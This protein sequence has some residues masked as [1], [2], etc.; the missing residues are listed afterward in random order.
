MKREKTTT[1]GCIR[2]NDR[3]SSAASSTG[4]DEESASSDEESDD[5]WSRIQSWL[6]DTPRSRYSRK[7]LV[8][9]SR[10][11]FATAQVIK[12]SSSSNVS[13][14]CTRSELLMLRDETLASSGCKRTQ[15]VVQPHVQVEW[16]NT[17]EDR[18]E[19]DY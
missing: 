4:S 10:N 16:E 12:S 8:S 9:Q 19:S 3:Q 17:V 14:P 7:R 1:C 18:D 2:R 13:D 15:A 11:L 6:K 5:S